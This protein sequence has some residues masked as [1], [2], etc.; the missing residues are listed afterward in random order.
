MLTGRDTQVA[1]ASLLPDLDHAGSAHPHTSLSRQQIVCR[2]CLTSQ[3]FQ[4]FLRALSTPQSTV[5]C[6]QSFSS[7]SQPDPA[8]KWLVS[9][10]LTRPQAVT[11]TTRSQ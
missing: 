5:C 9:N 11:L 10:S 4:T 1:R 7:I 6:T 8:P 3:S 2:Q